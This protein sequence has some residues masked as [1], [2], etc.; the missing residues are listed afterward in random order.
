[1][2]Y[3][4]LAALLSLFACGEP[5]TPL[6]GTPIDVRPFDPLD[7]TAGIHPSLIVLEDPANLYR[8]HPPSEDA[9]WDVQA[10]GEP[11]LAFYAFA[12]ALTRTPTGENQ[13]YVGVNLKR[14]SDLGLVAAG[15]EAMVR[16]MA[17]DAFQVVIDQFPNDV[18]YDADGTTS[19]NVSDYARSELEQ[20]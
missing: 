11:K 17:M 20:F 4:Y 19:H 14:M 10:L 2:K 12:S 16:Q 5:S 6:L 8:T 3:L 1:M 18:T 13:Y 15:K 9:K 7:V